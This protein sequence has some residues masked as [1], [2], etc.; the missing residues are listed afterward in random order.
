MT[1]QHRQHGGLVTAVTYLPPWLRCYIWPQ[2]HGR[3]DSVSP[4]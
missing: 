3:Q 1:L 4:S 2:Q